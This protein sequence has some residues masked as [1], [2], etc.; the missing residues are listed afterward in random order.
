[1]MRQHL[2]RKR[3]CFIGAFLNRTSNFAVVNTTAKHLSNRSLTAQHV[4]YSSAVLQ[5]PQPSNH[6]RWVSNGSMQNVSAW[7]IVSVLNDAKATSEHK[8]E[9]LKQWSALV[10]L[11]K[12]SIALEVIQ[13]D[14]LDLLMKLIEANDPE[15]M[16]SAYVSLIKLSPNQMIAQEL[17]RL[18]T[19]DL[20]ASH[21]RNKNA[22]LQ[23]A[24]CILLGSL[25]L[26]TQGGK[27][28][29]KSQ[30]VK[31]LMELLESPHDAIQRAAAGC[32]GNIAGN[33][34]GKDILLDSSDFVTELSNILSSDKCE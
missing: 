4:L 3:W 15:F 13:S 10:H 34:Q 20:L 8:S 29:A 27:H 28:V 21:L 14:I 12:D 24:G 2:N 11:E 33:P 23:A 32:L 1:M 9:L 6:I 31:N 18:N 7:D 19:V 5:I 22:R 16:F 30:V 26:D 17:V 25:A